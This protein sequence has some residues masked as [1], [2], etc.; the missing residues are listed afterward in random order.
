M[1]DKTRL[2]VAATLAA[3]ALLA[4]GCGNSAEDTTP[5]SKDTAAATVPSVATM[6]RPWA[7]V[8]SRYTG[9]WDGRLGLSSVAVVSGTVTGIEPADPLTDADAADLTRLHFATISVKVDEVHQ[10][11]LDADTIQVYEQYVHLD[12]LT[13]ALPTGLKVGLFLEDLGEGA[14][15]ELDRAKT[16]RVGPAGLVVQT[17]EGVTYPKDGRVLQGTLDGA[18]ALPKG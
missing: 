6:H 1:T 2:R 18:L 8:D 15:K 13:K 12:D 10:G 16:F 11:K 5:A 17:S 3:T 4:A 9:P 14:P 7:S